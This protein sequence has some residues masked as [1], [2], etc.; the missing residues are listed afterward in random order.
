MDVGSQP[1]LLRS[2]VSLSDVSI[3]NGVLYW[4]QD[5]IQLKGIAVMTDYE[6][7]EDRAWN[8]TEVGL[9]NDPWKMQIVQIPAN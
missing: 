3:F 8:V 4:L 5:D 1:V 2:G 7:D 6:S 9:F